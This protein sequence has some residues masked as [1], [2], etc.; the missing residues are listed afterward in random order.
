MK[1]VK[2]SV[3]ELKGLEQFKAV[4][5]KG[6]EATFTV[7]GDKAIN[8]ETGKSV[9]LDSIRRSWEIIVEEAQVDAPAEQITADEIVEDEKK[10]E[11]PAMTPAEYFTG[12]TVKLVDGSIGTVESVMGNLATVSV[13]GEEVPV[14][15]EALEVVEGDA[16]AENTVDLP[17]VTKKEA[18]VFNWLN[19][20]LAPYEEDFS[21]VTVEDIASGLEMSVASV[22]GVV[23]SLTKKGLVFTYNTDSED[24]ATGKKIDFDL[25]CRQE[26]FRDVKLEATKGAKL[27]KADKPA[28]RTA[29]ATDNKVTAKKTTPSA[30]SETQQAFLSQLIAEASAK[31]LTRAKEVTTKDYIRMKTD[32]KDAI[33][34]AG[35]NKKAAYVLIDIKGEMSRIEEA[36]KAITDKKAELQA[37]FTEELEFINKEGVKRAT[38]K[39][40]KSISDDIAG[41]VKWAVETSVKFNSSFNFAL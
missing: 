2:M 28:K 25:I 35:M 14:S 18:E 41:L 30:S 22:K 4:S 39:I 29:K 19:E 13:A 20:A 40:E 6:K 9:K 32:A 33:I 16:P 24:M 23:G 37:E 31:D 36:F 11:A 26:Q 5:D 10:E 34:V 8:V 1:T 3:K 12:K 15:I 27:E 7:E 38:I 17:A 21:D